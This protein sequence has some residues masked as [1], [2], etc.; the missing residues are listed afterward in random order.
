[1][2]DAKAEVSPVVAAIVIILVIAIAAT[3]GW[4][5]LVRQP[6]GPTPVGPPMQ[7]GPPGQPGMPGAPAPGA[8]APGVPSAPPAPTAPPGG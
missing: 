1:M 2:V 5:F 8:P 6:V 4:Y 7:Y 3:I